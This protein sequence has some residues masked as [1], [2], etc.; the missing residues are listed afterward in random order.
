MTIPRP[1]TVR[2]AETGATE[3]PGPDAELTGWTEPPECLITTDETGSG[4]VGLP[5][6]HPKVAALDVAKRLQYRYGDVEVMLTRW[7]ETIDDT[8]VGDGDDRARTVAYTAR[9]IMA[10][11]DEVVV[12]P[13][14]GVG[15]LPF[16]RS[17]YCDWRSRYLDRSGWT[18]TV[19]PAYD[20]PEGQGV[21]GL[22]GRHWPPN[23]WP[24]PFA[25]WSYRAFE[26]G[27]DQ[28]PV[29]RCYGALRRPLPAV[30]RLITSTWMAADD[31]AKLAWNNNLWV[32]GDEPP[33]ASWDLPYRRV[34]WV[35]GGGDSDDGLVGTAGGDLLLT[36]EHTNND[37]KWAANAG[38]VAALA[39]GC[40]R[41]DSIDGS[42]AINYDNLLFQSGRMPN[43]SAPESPLPDGAIWSP[44]LTSPP[45]F[46]PG[47]L[48]DVL[49]SEAQT[50]RFLL[51]WS[52][53]F[54][55]TLT[56]LGTPWDV[57]VPYELTVGET[58]LQVLQ[59]VVQDDATAYPGPAAPPT[60]HLVNK[61]ELTRSTA[62]YL[63]GI[64]HM[65]TPNEAA[66][67]LRRLAYRI[68]TAA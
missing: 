12:M 51:D 9:G 13:E 53:S 24:A 61:G 28:H 55:P 52:W 41:V 32:V 47:L 25:G 22:Y 27:T 26:S 44:L 64:R 10:E 8:L 68:S 40:W 11:L 15:A 49:L 1:L 18:S 20:D 17:R 3:P 21:V 54:T 43:P 31:G 5:R 62:S 33:Q 23:G 56:S 7:I 42:E 37:W 38:N 29:G 30:D 65:P 2:V 19:F 50:A 16:A 59:R 46:T 58:Y 36:W 57:E 6:E 45:G 34:G 66:V 60:L 4:R 48:F 14:A 67:N 35:S 63:R 39:Y